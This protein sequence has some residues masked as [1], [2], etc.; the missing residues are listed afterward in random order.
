MDLSPTYVEESFGILTDDGLYL[1]C[2]LV[3][4]GDMA[5]EALRAL[6]VWVPKAPLTKSSVITC[7]R[8]EVAPYGRSGHV[9]HLVFDLRGTGNSDAR[10]EAYELDLAAIRAWAGERFPVPDLN[11]SFFGRPETSSKQVSLWPLR[12]GV[13]MECYHYP[14]AGL[15]SVHPPVLY[16][17]TYGNFDR[18]DDALC[19]ALAQAGYD[20]YGIDPLRYLLH[21]SAKKR[22]TVELLQQDL[23]SLGQML[24]DAPFL[25]GQPI[26]A[27][28]ALFWAAEG[29]QSRGVIAIGQAQLGFKPRHIFDNSSSH[30][31]FLGRYVQ[32]IAPQPAAFV[33]LNHHPL[34]GD[35]NELAALHQNCGHP[36]RLEH[37]E[38]LTPE[39]LLDMLSWLRKVGQP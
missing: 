25:V 8:K 13:V 39:F 9:A 33:G 32:K 23:A 27:G 3:K 16:L 20:V 14:A 6:R 1:D 15:P 29:E 10:N 30:T 21:A 36:R 28:L 22:L 11:L 17:S 26:A 34:G 31:F 37:V 7:A 4:P 35:T 19:V 38:R 2:I 12:P 5:D 24:P 18:R